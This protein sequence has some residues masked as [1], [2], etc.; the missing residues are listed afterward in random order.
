MN[1][2]LLVGIV[3]LCLGSIEVLLTIILCFRGI[4]VSKVEN[5]RKR[6][7]D[8]ILRIMKYYSGRGS[9][10]SLSVSASIKMMRERLKFNLAP[11]EKSEYTTLLTEYDVLEK[12]TSRKW[13]LWLTLGLLLISGSI[14]LL[15]N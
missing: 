8:D 13:I 4:A 6:I 1:N 14:W 7:E 10:G 11:K 12:P 3:G 2:N 9:S 15:C 5:R